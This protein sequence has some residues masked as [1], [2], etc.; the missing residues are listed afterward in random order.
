ME[1]QWKSDKTFKL[2]ESALK[3]IKRETNEDN[4]DES[5]EKEISVRRTSNTDGSFSNVGITGD[6]GQALVKFPQKITTDGRSGTYVTT[7]TTV[8]W[9]QC[10]ENTQGGGGGERQPWR[11]V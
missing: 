8:I 7:F 2:R 1:G 5:S 10:K 4:V 9:V 11:H 6:C 3:S